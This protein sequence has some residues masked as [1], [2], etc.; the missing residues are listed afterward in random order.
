MRSVAKQ[1]RQR[2]TRSSRASG[3]S[4][5]KFVSGNRKGRSFVIKGSVSKS[6]SGKVTVSATRSG[7][8]GTRKASRKVTAKHG[9]FKVTLKLKRGRYIFRAS[10]PKTSKFA[11][12]DIAIKLA[13]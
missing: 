13:I 8:K 1:P 11:A 9:K 7:S 5:L 3:P 6:F 2:S 12:T 10:T 4:G